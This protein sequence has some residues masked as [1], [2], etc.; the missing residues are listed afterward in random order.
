MSGLSPGFGDSLEPHVDCRPGPAGRGNELGPAPAQ[1]G[2]VDTSSTFGGSAVMSTTLRSTPFI[3]LDS[4]ATAWR[5]DGDRT[6]GQPRV[7]CDRGSE[8]R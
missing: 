8:I 5:P 3:R 1:L 4:K 2:I 7:S 6:G